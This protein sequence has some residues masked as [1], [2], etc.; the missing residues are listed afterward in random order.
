MN[1]KIAKLLNLDQIT[2][3]M[4]EELC[5]HYGVSNHSELVRSLIRDRHKRIIKG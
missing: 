5:A 2:I 4:L 3:A 1:V